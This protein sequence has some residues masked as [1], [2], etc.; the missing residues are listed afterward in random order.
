MLTIR[1][2]EGNTII[3]TWEVPVTAGYHLHTNTLTDAQRALVTN[4]KN[5]RYSVTV[6]GSQARL[7]WLKLLAPDTVGSQSPSPSLSASASSSRSASQSASLSAS[8]SVSSSPSLSASVSPSLS[9]SQS[10]SVSASLSASRSAS[11]SPSPGYADYTR[12]STLTLPAD[13]T[14]LTTPYSVSE[15][16]DVRTINAVYVAQTATAQYAIHQFKT[17]VGAIPSIILLAQ[18]IQTTLDPATSTVY[19]QI[20]NRVSGLWETID[21]EPGIYNGAYTRYGGAYQNY[22]TVGANT[23]FSLFGQIPDNTAYVDDHGVIA[24]RIYQLMP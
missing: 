19:L 17:F 6:T 7:T 18:G 4:W 3:A 2:K 13:D 23:D 14:D 5:L 8:L 1:L 15:Y 11:A 10:A 9:A 20:Y 12:E 16:E 24:C 21:R 22:S